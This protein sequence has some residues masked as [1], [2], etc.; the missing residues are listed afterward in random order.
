MTHHRK[1]RLRR[2]RRLAPATLA[3]TAGAAVTALL[4]PVAGRRRRAVLRDKLRAG[5]RRAAR[6]AAT[7]AEYERGRVAGLLH[8]VFGASTPPPEEDTV[9]ADKVSSEVLGKPEFAGQ[10][11]TLEACDG[12]VTLRG[13]IANRDL[14]AV[15]REEIANVAGVGKVVSHLHLP[16]EP[17]P[18]KAAS[19]AAS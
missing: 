9:L 2:L 12:V 14:E 8:R 13:E 10:T 4:D 3:A 19:I 15:L 16:G 1:S 6:D 5:A 18:N 11:V 7:E 17:P